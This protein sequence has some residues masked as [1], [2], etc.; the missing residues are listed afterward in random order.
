MTSDPN[1]G[2]GPAGGGGIIGA[3]IGA[4]EAAA[5]PEAAAGGALEATGGGPAEGATAGV[6]DPDGGGAATGGG[7]AEPPTNPA[8]KP[9][10]KSAPDAA[11][12]TPPAVEGSDGAAAPLKPGPPSGG[13]ELPAKPDDIGNDGDDNPRAGLNGTPPPG[14]L[15]DDNGEPIDGANGVTGGGNCEPDCPLGPSKPPKRAFRRRMP[16]IAAVQTIALAGVSPWL[17]SAPGVSARGG[18]G[19]ATRIG[20]LRVLCSEPGT[21]R[22]SVLR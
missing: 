3:A 19:F 20:R 22:R 8:L 15:P 1:G 2:S 18:W 6:A 7:N 4:A 9:L 5:G 21:R 10:V 13:A 17:C 12:G 14:P 16:R 11:G